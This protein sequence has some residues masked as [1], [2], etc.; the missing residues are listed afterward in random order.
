MNVLNKILTL[1]TNHVQEA[2]IKG[3]RNFTMQ[4]GMVL[5]FVVGPWLV[6]GQNETSSC[7]VTVNGVSV[8]LSQLTL[9]PEYAYSVGIGGQTC[10]DHP[11]TY[12]FYY[13]I[14]GETYEGNCVPG[15]AVCQNTTGS[16]GG[17]Q[18]WSC[19]EASEQ[20]ITPM[21]DSYPVQITYK[22]GDYCNGN[23]RE[24]NIFLQC[25]PTVLGQ[26]IS[27]TENPMC[28]YNIIMST[29]LVCDIPT[30]DCTYVFAN[31]S[32]VDLSG[33]TVDENQ[34]YQFSDDQYTYYLNICGSTMKGGCVEGTELCQAK[35]STGQKWSLGSANSQTFV[36]A[37]EVTISYSNGTLCSNGQPRTNTVTVGCD[38]STTGK[39]L[40]ITETAACTYEVEMVSLYACL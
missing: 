10:S 30:N 6:C 29:S 37:D 35:P 36:P 19:G 34:A 7:S 15:T 23:D 27:V 11:C 1:L 2:Q 5:V 4:W 24:T 18:R 38:P 3:E 39:I 32:F 14:C 33:M 22:G 20:V 40:S 13:N 28:V 12:E 17:T 26:A 25:D 21:V 16:N 8:D 31:G 9:P